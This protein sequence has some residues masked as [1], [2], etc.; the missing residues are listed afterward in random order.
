MDCLINGAVIDY[1]YKKYKIGSLTCNSEES[2]LEETDWIKGKAETLV[3]DHIGE[4][5]YDLR[6]YKKKFLNKK[7]PSTNH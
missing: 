2:V 5:I 7:N 1:L 6:I 3:E 4:Y